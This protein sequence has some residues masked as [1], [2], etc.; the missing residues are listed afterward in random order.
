MRSVVDIL[1]DFI[2][3]NSMFYNSLLVIKMLKNNTPIPVQA[4]LKYYKNGAERQDENLELQQFS[5]FMRVSL[6]KCKVQDSTLDTLEYIGKFL[7]NFCKNSENHNQLSSEG[8]EII[9]GFY[10]IHDDLCVS[11]II[12]FSG[13][14]ID[15]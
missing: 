8:Q 11:K 6:D 7:S 3:T 12:D 1:H 5:L 14:E 10:N 9:N 15:G 2:Y 4:F 13:C